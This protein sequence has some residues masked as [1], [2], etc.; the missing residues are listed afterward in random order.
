MGLIVPAVCI[1]CGITNCGTMA[2]PSIDI[3]IRMAQPAPDAVCSVLPRLAIS[4]MKPTKQTADE[5]PPS[6]RMPMDDGRTPNPNAT[7][8]SI[9]ST[10]MIVMKHASALPP[11]ICA[12]VSGAMR[13]RTSVPCVRSVTRLTPNV[14]TQ[15]IRPQT[16]PWGN[17]TSNALSGP[18]RSRATGLDVTLSGCHSPPGPVPRCCAVAPVKVLSS[19]RNRC[20]GAT[21]GATAGSG[22]SANVLSVMRAETAGSVNIFCMSAAACFINSPSIIPASAWRTGSTPSS[23]SLDEP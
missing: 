22:R 23:T 11:R 20:T 12:R 17:V 19:P 3:G 7:V 13:S 14:M 15:P 21:C 18:R 9:T 1:H 16:M 4:I 10:S 2:P 6:T 8:S 5:T